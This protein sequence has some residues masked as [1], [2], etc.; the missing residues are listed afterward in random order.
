MNNFYVSWFWCFIINFP[1]PRNFKNIPKELDEA[2]MLD[3]CN[4][5][6]TFWYIIF[7]LLKTYAPLQLLSLTQD[8]FGMI[9]YY[10]L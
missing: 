3:G 1:M 7:P 10:L 6:Q 9:I 2:A 5:L 4:N 8:G